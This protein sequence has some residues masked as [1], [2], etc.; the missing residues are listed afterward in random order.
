MDNVF[1]GLSG[2][3]SSSRFFIE[4]GAF[5]G[6]MKSNSL[7]FELKYNWTGLLVEPNPILVSMMV[8]KKRNAYILPYCLSPIKAPTVVEFD[9]AGNLGGIIYIEKNGKRRFPGNM[10]RPGWLGPIWRKTIHV[11]ISIL[12]L[13]QNHEYYIYNKKKDKIFIPLPLKFLF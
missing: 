12:S 8:K 7:Y 13:W 5:D 11:G 4:A 10:E 3:N 1:I 6:E 9:A 2:S